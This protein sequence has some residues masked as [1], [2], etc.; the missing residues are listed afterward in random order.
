MS[1]VKFVKGTVAQ[2]KSNTANY[3]DNGVIYFASDD[4]LIFAHGN[5]Y[6]LSK[7]DREK[8]LGGV[9]NITLNESDNTLKIEYLDSSKAA[10]FVAL[11][12]VSDTTNGL[13]TPEQ[14][15]TL[16][17]A[18]EDIEAL[19]KAVA[20]NKVTSSG[21]TIVVTAGSAD[22]E[23][24]TPTNIDVNIDNKT[25]VKDA[26]GKLGVASQALTQYKGDGKTVE[27]GEL[28]EAD[29]S[30][31]IST[32]IKIAEATDLAANEAQAW[33][34]VDKSGDPIEGSA[35][36]SVKKDNAFVNGSLGHIDDTIDEAT[37]AITSGT[38]ADSIN[39]VYINNEGKYILVQ[40]DIEQFLKESEFGDGLNV[41]NHKVAVKLS[42]SEESAKYLTI[43]ANGA[44]SLSGIDT[45]IKAASVSIE[46]KTEGHV[47]V[48]KVSGA[49]GTTY[50]ISEEDIAS[51]EALETLDQEAVKNVTV[52]G[53]DA[54]VADNKAIVE[55]GGEAIK[56]NKGGEAA[57]KLNEGGVVV[58]G[59]NVYEAIKTMEAALLWYDAD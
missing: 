59:N 38:G 57:G 18:V 35:R 50:T 10:T 2:Y 46:E 43:D 27:V 32:T 3:A 48:T 41:S 28:D 6:G 49:S 53:V 8:F 54:T 7:E 55:I 56:V 14:K 44:I 17:G 31:T 34:L 42:T 21:K 24:V 37:G 29:N 39:L 20:L 16:E 1:F 25:I 4:N 5:T 45:A 19:E 23:T 9:S 40:I 36:I 15:A 47:K 30:K 52:N 13:M 11:N 33:Q 12:P 22:G 58:N 51:A 26:D